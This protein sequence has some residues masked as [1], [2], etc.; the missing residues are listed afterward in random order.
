MDDNDALSKEFL[1]QMVVTTALREPTLRAAVETLHLPV[2]SRGLDACC[3][4]GMQTP[5]LAEAVGSAGRV[6]GLDLNPQIIRYAENM[7]AEAGLSQRISFKV[8]SVA[9]LPFEEDSF[10]WAWSV[11]CVG[12]APMEPQPLI[13][14]LARVVKPGGKIAILAWSSQQ[15]LPGHPVLEAHLNATASGIAPFSAGREPGLH[16]M[17]ALGWFQE[18]GLVATTANT[19][20][21]SA[22]APLDDDIRDALVALLQMRW[23]GVK[24]E[25]SADDWAEYQRLCDPES[26]D[27]IVNRPDYYAFFTYSMIQGRVA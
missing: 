19:F 4:A 7:V 5:L 24:D 2:G 6:V 15:L 21:G 10:D 25:L 20:T 14:E 3:G 23:P 17:R 13:K 9:E 1:H 8:G 22:Y 27:F 12:Y 18:V 16:F 11:D 26:P